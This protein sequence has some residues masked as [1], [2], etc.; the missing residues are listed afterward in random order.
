MYKESEK[1]GGKAQAPTLCRFIHAMSFIPSDNTVRLSPFK[2]WRTGDSKPE[3]LEYNEV[4]F[5]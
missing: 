1:T 2:K 4:T 5:F 3:N